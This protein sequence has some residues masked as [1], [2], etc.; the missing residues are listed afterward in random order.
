V[1][2]GFAKRY[3]YRVPLG[4]TIYE[5]IAL[6]GTQERDIDQLLGLKITFYA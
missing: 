3:Y 6:L 2:G 1:A 4:L 5:I